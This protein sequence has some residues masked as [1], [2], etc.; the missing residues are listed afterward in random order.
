[1][2]EPI[3]INGAYMKK[4]CFTV[5]YNE[6]SYELNNSC[7]WFESIGILCRHAISV[8]TTLD[9]VTLFLEKIKNKNKNLNQWRKD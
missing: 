6:P 7:C 4:I 3:L 9:D 5:Y 1:V 8:L 2:I